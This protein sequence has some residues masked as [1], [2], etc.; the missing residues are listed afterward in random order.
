LL[1]LP[2]WRRRSLTRNSNVASHSWERRA[3][4]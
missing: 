4:K 1:R 2:T 3:T